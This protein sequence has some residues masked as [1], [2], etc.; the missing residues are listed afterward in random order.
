MKHQFLRF[1]AL[2]LF[3]SVWTVSAQKLSAQPFPPLDNGKV[4]IEAE[5][6]APNSTINV[7]F[8]APKPTKLDGSSLASTVK[9]DGNGKFT[10]VVK[11]STRLSMSAIAG[12]QKAQ[13]RLEPPAP[14]AMPVLTVKGDT[15]EASLNGSPAWTARLHP[16]TGVKL[17]PAII[18]R[19]IFVPDGASVMQLEANK[20][21][22]IQ[23][24]VVSGLVSSLEA[25]GTDVRVNV[26]IPN[27]SSTPISTLM[28][29][30]TLRR[31]TGQPNFSLLER[32]VYQPDNIL[33]ETFEG[34]ASKASQGDQL[35]PN[36]PEVSQTT[37][38]KFA[39]QDPTNPFYKIYEGAA[40]KALNKAVEAQTAFSLAS[41]IAVPF[42][43]YIR[44]AAV[45]V[46]LKEWDF[47]DQALR[48]ARVAYG[49]A[50]YDPAIPVSS[51]ALEAYGNP[52]GV[53]RELFKDQNIQRGTVWLAFLRDTMPR[54]NQSET[55]FLEL[56][57]YLDTQ[58]AG[59]GDAWR[60]MQKQIAQGT[61]YTFGVSRIVIFSLG[62]LLAL[63]AAFIALWLVLAA[64][65][66]PQQSKDLKS[67]GG[68]TGAWG[69]SPLLRLRHSLSA[70][71]TLTEKIVL[72][73]LLALM[74]G[75]LGTWTWST[76]A[77]ETLRH[78]AFNLGTL[79]G[80]TFW[81]SFATKPTSSGFDAIRGLASLLDGDKTRATQN[82]DK[83]GSNPMALNNL[84]VLAL[85]RGDNAQAN[86][87]FQAALQLQPSMIEAGLNSR[88]NTVSSYR[89]DFHKA[90]F[91]DSPM[92][93]FPE[94]K[95]I[96]DASQ[97]KLEQEFVH[98]VSDP[99]G[100]LINLPFGLPAWAMMAVAVLILAI[101][102][103]NL[104]SL[105][106]PRIRSAR[107]APRSVVYH[108]LA[109]LV[110][111]SG[112][113]DEVWGIILLVPWALAGSLLIIYFNRPD[114]V[115]SILAEQKILN[116]SSVPAMLDLK[117]YSIWVIA[118]IAGLYLINFVGWLLETLAWNKKMKRSA[119][120]AATQ[121]SAGTVQTP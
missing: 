59:A 57:N 1:T 71:L 28:E 45:F 9:A 22:V 44:E 62:T 96:V 3:A 64:K 2:M 110:P 51:K 20:G 113:A 65:Y 54:F 58:S 39:A 121:T 40:F 49:N 111:G 56:A 69:K 76:R 101:L 7:A 18:G 114:L 82:L 77:L 91:G 105:L 74:L 31:L 85:D 73:T 81:N 79:G 90:V 107:D 70:Y 92:L 15:L 42:F 118:G 99:W 38:A 63:I 103:L 100:Y 106:I 24:F 87:K 75:A 36:F 102:I 95:D 11:A 53:A 98:M 19:D 52:L 50:G 29:S 23:R 43:V 14:A 46:R 89:L 8:N 33:L 67:V 84:G 26:S 60:V 5:G 68:A 13:L 83:A 47:A 94:P 119:Q 66:S 97:G 6:F 55:V 41:N 37:N 12:T 4:T 108:F 116:L 117:S 88:A 112:L 78:P 34:F 120:I 115:P 80:V 32:P 25:Q 48:F 86:Q 27:G 72:V 21:T 35:K 30:F 61:P 16:K 104:L 10:L 109:L 17:N 93:A